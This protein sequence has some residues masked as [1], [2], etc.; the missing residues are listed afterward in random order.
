MPTKE[1]DEMG[2]ATPNLIVSPEPGTRF[3]LA[4]QS[5]GIVG[6]YY[7]LDQS[8][9]KNKLLNDLEVYHSV[10]VVFSQSQ[11]NSVN[12]FFTDQ[13]CMLAAEEHSR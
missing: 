11:A 5:E 1:D 13:R 6:Q 4:V 8:K 3:G 2:V 12:Y 7:P 10:M 9:L